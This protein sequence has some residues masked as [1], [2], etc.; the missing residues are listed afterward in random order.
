[1]ERAVWSFDLKSLAKIGEG[2]VRELYA[3]DEKRMLIATTDRISAYDVV[4][5]TPI[6]GKGRVLTALSRFWFR[7]FAEIV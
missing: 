5:P 1:M 6:P 3:V 2:K 4:L 7:R